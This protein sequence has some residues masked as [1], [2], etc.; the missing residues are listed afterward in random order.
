MSGAMKRLALLAFALITPIP[1]V[2]APF[3]ASAAEGSRTRTTEAPQVVQPGPL[4]GA[5][6]T[7][8]VP[9][10]RIERESEKMRRDRRLY[11]P[12]AD[13][14]VGKPRVIDGDTLAIGDTVVHLYGVAAPDEGQSCTKDGRAWRCGERATLALVYEVDDHWVSCR[15]RALDREGRR[16]AVCYAGDHDLGALMV[17]Q[18]WALADRR[19]A[20]DYVEQENRARAA[21]F[22]LWQGTFTPPWK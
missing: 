8:I 12:S 13:T 16:L 1:S 6:E 3:A 2:W 19:Y 7:V 4:T 17:R 10:S 20:L 14:L 22:G 18:G 15:L 11:A 9:R 5:G 21:G